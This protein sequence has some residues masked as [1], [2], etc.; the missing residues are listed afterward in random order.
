LIVS[1]SRLVLMRRSYPKGCVCCTPNFADFF[2][3]AI[4]H[5]L[6]LVVIAHR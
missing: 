3:S 5:H 4:L 1:P 2:F 6:A